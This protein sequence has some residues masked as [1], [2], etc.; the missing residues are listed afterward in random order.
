MKKGINHIDL[1]DIVFALK[2][3]C[4]L[5]N[6]KKGF[7]IDDADHLANKRIRT[8]GE[9]LYS[10]LMPTMRKFQKSTRGKLSVI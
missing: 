1:E 4:N 2:Y 6:H 10:H 9:L 3:L 7:F 5:S 8:A